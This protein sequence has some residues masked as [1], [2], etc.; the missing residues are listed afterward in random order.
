METKS[1][2][3]LELYLLPALAAS[4]SGWRLEEAVNVGLC[5][6]PGLAPR[7]CM[8]GGREGRAHGNAL[9]LERDLLNP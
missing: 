3:H 7:V 9:L 1:N 5:L 8:D 6:L 2:V 4:F